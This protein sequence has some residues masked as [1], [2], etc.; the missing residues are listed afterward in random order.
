MVNLSHKEVVAAR[1]KGNKAK[2]E[3]E[4]TTVKDITV[5]GIVHRREEDSGAKESEGI[6]I[7]AKK[8]RKKR[9]TNDAAGIPST[10]VRLCM[11]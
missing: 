4:D 9:L 1:K 6:V 11:I 2:D 7:V 5:T 8:R 3:L 10:V